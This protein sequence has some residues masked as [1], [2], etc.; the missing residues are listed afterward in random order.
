MRHS[1]FGTGLVVTLLLTAAV[2]R[3][4]GESCRHCVEPRQERRL[5]AVSARLVNTCGNARLSSLTTAERARYCRWVVRVAPAEA[6]RQRPGLPS[7][8]Y[9]AIEAAVAPLLLVQPPQVQGE[10]ASVLAERSSA[11]GREFAV[12]ALTKRDGTWMV[13]SVTSAGAVT[14]APGR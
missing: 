14:G 13:E 12:V 2:S 7:P 6:E 4:D 1:A 3:A 11:A 5:P 10:Q 9:A 8:E